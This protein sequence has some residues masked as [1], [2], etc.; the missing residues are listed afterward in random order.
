MQTSLKGIAKRAK[1][2]K[3]CKFQSL[4]REITYALLINCFEDM[5]RK[6]AVGV[7]EV[8]Y[9]E[10]KENLIPNIRSLL[11]RVRNGSYHAALV[12]RHYIPK[13][14][15]KVRPLG[16][17]TT[18][19]KLLQR[20]VRTI[21]EAIYEQDFLPSSFGYRPK[22]SARD[23]TDELQRKLNFGG[24]NWVVE[25]DIKGF[26]DNINHE[27][28]LN[29]LRM[30]ID[31]ENFIG[32]IQKWL[33]AGVLDTDG[34]VLDSLTGTPQGGV[35]SPML[36]NI[37]MHYVLNE[38]YDKVM[39]KHCK[40]NAYLCVYADDFVCAFEYEEDARKFYGVL[41]KR[42]AK[43]DLEIAPEK[44][45][46]IKFSRKECAASETFDFLSL[47]FRWEKSKLKN[48]YYVMRRSAKKRFMRAIENVDKWIKDNRSTPITTLIKSLNRKL[49]G[50]YNYF[51][52]PGN[53]EGLKKYV[54]IVRLRLYKWLGR[55][56]Q[57]SGFTWKTFNHLLKVLPLAK[58]KINYNQ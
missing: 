42:L 5:N 55:R 4:T 19:D 25:A 29:M 21:L 8:D 31:D 2:D 20:A 11:D 22:R 47:E 49:I 37:Y 27:K 28:L 17:P 10:Y 1:E 54:Y 14:N 3:S 40:G 41:P 7:D 16:I 12:R 13:G 53:Y 23:A 18:E 36:A 50:Y 26:F 32:L 48:T 58:P 35:I 6:S 24:F 51:G 33:R 38:W 44:T 15:G 43:Y 56:S 30:R 34:K 52:V 45:K 39:R 46:L 57:R 9:N